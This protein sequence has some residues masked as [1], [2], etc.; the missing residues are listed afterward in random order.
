MTFPKYSKENEIN[1]NKVI[2]VKY[3]NCQPYKKMKLFTNDIKLALISSSSFLLL[4]QVQPEFATTYYVIAGSLL[5]Y[6]F[7]NLYS[8]KANNNKIKKI[9]KK[10]FTVK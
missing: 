8:H 2:K 9:N 4:S 1:L 10:K 3:K 6:S 5:I 7:A